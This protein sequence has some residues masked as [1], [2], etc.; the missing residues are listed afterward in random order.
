VGGDQADAEEGIWGCLRV[1]NSSCSVDISVLHIYC[2]CNTACHS[3]WKSC[4]SQGV[5][6]IPAR[7][8]T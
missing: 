8:H 1:L 3:S 6:P 5:D 4:I 2:I 7:M